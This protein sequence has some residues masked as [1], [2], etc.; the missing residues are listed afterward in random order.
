VASYELE[1]QNA[2][3]G[4]RVVEITKGRV[5]I[6]EKTD[7]GIET[8]IIRLEDEVPSYGLRVTGSGLKKQRIERI[9]KAL[10]ESPMLYVPK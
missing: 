6:E 1:N 3:Y 7:K 9:R 2:G 10:E 4:L 5:V 8:V